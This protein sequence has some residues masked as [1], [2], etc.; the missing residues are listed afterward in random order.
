M[1]APPGSGK[2]MLVARLAG[3]LPPLTPAEALEVTMMHSVVGHLG[4]GGL[5]A[6]PGEISL[7]HQGV[8]FL[9]EL[10]EFS[11]VAIDSF[12]QPLE[13][14]SVEVAR[15]NHHV[16]YPARFQLIA[17][18]NPCRCGYLGDS[19]HACSRVPSCGQ[20]YQAK[21]SGPLMDRFDL[22][23]E[24]PEISAG[25]LLDQGKGEPSQ[26]VAARVAAARQFGS[27]RRKDKMANAMISIDELDKQIIM[28]KPAE[29]LLRAAMDQAHLSAA[30]IIGL[31][32]Y[33]ERLLILLLRIGSAAPPWPKH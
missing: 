10:A 1:V 23:I 25:V 2:S 9:D 6:R 32:G 27:L 28:E 7:S 20:K 5:R 19:G 26:I 18:M 8:L 29:E 13:T 4:G 16:T 15:A 3:L 11:S 12:R 31:C 17:A 14:G 33:R 30:S 24:V 22:I 21:I